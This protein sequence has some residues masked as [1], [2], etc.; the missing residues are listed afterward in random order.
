MEVAAAP[1]MKADADLEDAV[2]KIAHGSVRRAPEE[3]ERLVLLEELAGVELFDALQE[4]GRWRVVA[5]GAG[6][7][8]GRSGRRALGRAR[9]LA[10][11]ATGF[12]R[13]RVR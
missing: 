5:A 2:R 11:S 6:G 7:L 10:R 3:L 4:L 13:A 8:V 12:G 9:G 1:V